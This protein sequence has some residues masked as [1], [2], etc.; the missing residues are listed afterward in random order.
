MIS[1]YTILALFFLFILIVIDPNVGDY[2]ILLLKVAKVNFERS[3]WMIR[4]HPAIYSSPLGKW[5]M[6]RKYMR[7]VEK[8]SQ[9]LSKKNDDAV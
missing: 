1:N 8:L 2:I 6:M 7:T 5:W 9:K 3:I 4:F